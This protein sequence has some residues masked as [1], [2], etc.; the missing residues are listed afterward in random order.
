MP[1]LKDYATCL[2][3][4]VCQMHTDA[5]GQSL[6]VIWAT[7][8]WKE[9]LVCF[10]SRFCF[11]QTCVALSVSPLAF[12]HPVH[13][14]LTRPPGTGHVATGNYCENLLSLYYIIINPPNTCWNLSLALFKVWKCYHLIYLWIAKKNKQSVLCAMGMVTLNTYLHFHIS[15]QWKATI[16]DTPLNN[17]IFLSIN[18]I[19]T[20]SPVYG[21]KLQFVEVNM[22]IIFEELMLI[23]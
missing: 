5:K 18:T 21:S 1:V 11:I 19:N 8:P 16:H 13:H 23:H 9:N 14:N 15:V 20:L 10:C 6:T 7:W 2:S 3:A 12:T 17:S 22:N 4:A